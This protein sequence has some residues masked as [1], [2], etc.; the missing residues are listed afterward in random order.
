MY[1]V[2]TGADESVFPSSPILLQLPFTVVERTYISSLEPAR[3]AMEVECVVTNTPGSSAFFTGGRDLI[4]LA[5]NA[6]VHDM[7]SANCT[8]VD[9][10]VPCP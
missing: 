6:Q 7:V 10:D 4:C 1:K 8:V 2:I 3:D 9:D 5:I